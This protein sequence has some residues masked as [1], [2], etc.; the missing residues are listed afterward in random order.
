MRCP[1]LT[2][3]IGRYPPTLCRASGTDAMPVLTIVLRARYA[4]SGTD[5]CYAAT[6]LKVSKRDPISVLKW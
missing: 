4:V 5:I 2:A 1:V 3:A 6:S